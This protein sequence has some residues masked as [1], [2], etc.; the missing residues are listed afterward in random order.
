MSIMPLYDK[1]KADDFKSLPPRQTAVECV[2]KAEA[3]V[4]IKEVLSV[5]CDVS[6]LACEAVSGEARYGGRVDFKAL[7]L[8]VGGKADTIAYY[9]DFNDKIEDTC[10]LPTSKLQC[11]LSVVESEVVSSGKDEIK[12]VCVIEAAVK[13]NNI[14]EITVVSGGEGF[15]C[16]QSSANVS[17]FSAEGKDV[18]EA[19]EEFEEKFM[20]TKILLSDAAAIVTEAAAGVDTIIVAGEAV[21]NLTYLA[22]E[23]DGERIGNIKRILTFRH[24]IDAKGA[25]PS[26]KAFADCEIKSLKVNA[27]VDEENRLTS[28]DLSASID[29]TAA[30]YGG[31]CVSFVDDAFSTDSKLELSYADINSRM[32]ISS[33]GF[34][35][36]LETLIALDKELASAEKVMATLAGRAH[37]ANVIPSAGGVT[38]EGI[39]SAVVL[40]AAAEG[41]GRKIQSLNADIP[42]SVKLD[43]EGARKEDIVNVKAAVFDL[44]AKSRKGREIEV[45]MRLKLSVDLFSRQVIKALCAVEGAEESKA[46]QSSVTIYFPSEKESLWDV[47]KQLSAAPDFIKANNPEAEIPGAQRIFIYRQK[48]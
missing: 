23:E 38:V 41:E 43:I 2:L 4:T 33:Y 10:V 5:C 15:F 21:V 7:F 39:A 12:I 32:F 45:V 35:K 31:V 24:E 44:E 47:A 1:I 27:V 26:D 16:N 34:E 37:I 48:R 19:G 30:A 40:Y 6:L 11:R 42:F 36:S 28:I 3:G 46:P 18:C 9:A 17:N 22:E 25:L 20:I 29:I 14:S 8:D 13:V